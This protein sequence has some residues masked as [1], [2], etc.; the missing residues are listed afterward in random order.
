MTDTTTA[1]PQA[2]PTSPPSPSSSPQ[3]SEV[4]INQSPVDAPNPIGSQAPDKPDAD[5]R[6]ES[7]E[8]AFQ[9]ASSPPPKGSRVAEK[10]APRAAEARMGHNQP[11]EETKPE[12]IDLKKRPVEA[13]RGEHG[14]F[15]PR[16]ETVQ[17]NA[18]QN[19]ANQAN[20]LD[21]Q[22]AQNAQASGEYKRL[23]SHAP[24]AEP[25]PRFSEGGKRDWADTP[26][27]IRG[28]VYRMHQEY[29]KAYQQYRGAAEAFQ[30][31]AR[32]HAM[33]QEHGT[34]LEKALT[35]Y[36]SM[37]QK[38]RA[39]PIAGL[40]VIIHNLGLQDPQTGQR[41]GLRDIAYHVLSQSP[42]QLQRIQQGN[43][44]SAQS[45]QIGA[46]HQ[47]IA[48]LKSTLQ[49]WQTAQ[50]FTY[51]RS[52]VDQ[53]ADQHPRFDELGELIENELKLGF[54]LEQAYQRAEL[55]Q[56]ATHA[57]Q[58]RTASAQTRQ[59]DRSIS[60][61]PGVAPSNGASRRPREPSGSPRDAVKN[62]MARLGGMH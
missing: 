49:Q 21:A 9:K 41:L 11:P 60:G 20:A 44:Q 40:D 37:E 26:E 46:L 34:T 42:E 10:P 22:Y 24:F 45:H 52:A 62:A 7:I 58:T 8:K 3:T 59:T 38:L 14:H 61:S 35:S 29:G 32:F 53:F 17:G 13:P 19:R 47:E 31:I 28:D 27:N 2:A 48:G 25:P 43:A 50:Q 51:T 12:R 23:P 39:D 16:A 15:A 6:R 1:P 5:R 30:P 56:P 18:G 4:V 54:N 36:T 33:A 55:L 57:A